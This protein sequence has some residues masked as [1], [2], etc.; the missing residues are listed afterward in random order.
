MW[1]YTVVVSPL[2]I[3]QYSSTALQTSA[4]EMTIKFNQ[5]EPMGNI[6][7]QFSPKHSLYSSMSIHMLPNQQH[8]SI[9][10]MPNNQ[11]EINNK[12]FSHNTCQY[13]TNMGQ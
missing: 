12:K 7:N 10:P 9:I 3:M 2:S 8:E 4:S 6:Q 11:T 5:Q 13:N 1:K